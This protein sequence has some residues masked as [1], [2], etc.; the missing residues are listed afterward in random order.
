M[1]IGGV[2][3]A[4]SKKIT[5]LE[6]R[7]SRFQLF[8]MKQQKFQDDELLDPETHVNS[9]SESSTDHESDTTEDPDYLETASSQMKRKLNFKTPSAKRINLASF[10][11]GCD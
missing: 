2:D 10:A 1:A 11:S 5:I 7:K 6:E 4:V 8:Q 3:A 9:T